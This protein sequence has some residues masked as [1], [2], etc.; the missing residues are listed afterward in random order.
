MQSLDCSADSLELGDLLGRVASLS[1]FDWPLPP[2]AMYAFGEAF[3]TLCLQLA[4]FKEKAGLCPLDRE[5]RKQGPDR[6]SS[7]LVV[8]A[9]TDEI[10]VIQFSR[11]LERGPPA[12][13]SSEEFQ[14]RGR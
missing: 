10:S 7:T 5:V 2:R 8:C 1:H 13:D 12:E 9:P 3:L 14:G 6:D 11:S 4:K